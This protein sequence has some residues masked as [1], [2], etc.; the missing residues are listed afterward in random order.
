MQ[1]NGEFNLSGK[2]I[3]EKECE[4]KHQYIIERYSSLEGRI[5][6]LENKFWW[7][8]TLLVGNLTGVIMLLLKGNL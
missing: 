6:S 4:I 5:K 2:F 1:I 8:I 3:L 7:I